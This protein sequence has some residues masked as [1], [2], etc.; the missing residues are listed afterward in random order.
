MHLEGRECA[1]GL[2]VNAIL[3]LSVLS[4]ELVAKTLPTFARLDSR[5]RLPLH[6]SKS[7]GPL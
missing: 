5:A 6:R 4:L 2:E 7:F 1:W 3:C